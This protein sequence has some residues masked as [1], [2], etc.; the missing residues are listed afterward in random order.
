MMASSTVLRTAA[1]TAACWR[2]SANAVASKR[3]H[4]AMPTIPAWAPQMRA[5]GMGP[6]LPKCP[7]SKVTA[8]TIMSEITNIA[9][10]VKASRQR[11]ESHNSNGNKSSTGTTTSHQISGNT[12]MIIPVIAAIAA[13]TVQP[14]MTSRRGVGTRPKATSPSI[15]GATVMMPIASDANQ[16]RHVIRKGT[17]GLWS[18]LYATAPA[19]PEIAVP[20]SAA[21]KNPAT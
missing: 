10:D 17:S 2:R 20:T 19:T 8:Q 9:A 4:S 13:R 3:A 1:T 16:C 14:S 6:I 21:A 15:I 18:S 7:I 11:T 12:K 5:S